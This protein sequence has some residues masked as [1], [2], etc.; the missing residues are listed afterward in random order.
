VRGEKGRGGE[1]VVREGSCVV[2]A[3]WTVAVGVRPILV[4]VGGE[5]RGEVWS[6]RAEDVYVA[7]VASRARQ[8]HCA[9]THALMH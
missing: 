3:L 1:G 9:R 4:V 5:R 7:R 6:Q 8:D 2:L